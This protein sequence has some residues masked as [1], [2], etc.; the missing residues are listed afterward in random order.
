MVSPKMSYS[1]ERRRRGGVALAG[2]IGG[3]VAL[4]IGLGLGIGWLLDRVL[5]TA[6]LFLIC[7]VLIGFV[8]SFFLTYKLA[9]GVTE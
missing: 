1:S 9:M 3:F 2:I 7:G 4:S 5:H 6:P 8:V